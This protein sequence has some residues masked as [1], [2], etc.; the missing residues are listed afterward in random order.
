MAATS[1]ANWSLYPVA[2]ADIRSVR[3]DADL[4][5]ALQTTEACIPRG[6]GRCYGDAAL[7]STIIQMTRLNRFLDFDEATGTL[8]CE[9]GVS[10]ADI[11]KVF[12]PRG[13]FLP[14]TPGT[15]FVT[16]GGAMASDVHGKN[17]HAA[18]SFSQHVEAFDLM[19]PDGEVVTCTR[20][21]HADLFA[22]TLGGMGLTGIILRATF[23]LIPVESAFIRQET[24]K[25]RNLVEI[26]H[27]FEAS[28]DWTYSV[29]WIDC[30]ARGR[31]RGR[32]IMMRGEHATVADLVNTRWVDSP[33]TLPSKRKLTVPFALPSFTLNPWTVRAFN[34]AYYGKAPQGTHASIID[35]DTFFYPLDS[36]LHWNRIYGK[37]GFV[38][39]QFVLPKDM[40][41]SGLTQILDRIAAA[42]HGSFLAVLKLFGQQNDLIAFP[43]EG[44]TLALDFP[45]RPG[46]FDFLDALDRIVL[47]HGGRLYLTK[48]ARMAKATFWQ[49]YANADRFATLKQRIDP[50]SRLRSLQSD[51]L[52]LTSDEAPRNV[53]LSEAA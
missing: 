37:R 27:L 52:G 35:Y 22:A 20:A 19:L 18:G 26:M 6:L 53:S 38:Q 10:F 31:K 11:L 14:V 24:V 44:Y 49:S 32:S 33:L 39:H 50:A 12:V 25:A 2:Q 4:R 3:N 7:S 51:R 29:A 34:M 47:D 1:V 21:E 40:S 23:R 5:T 46:L 13:W 17:H 15:K 43:K 41:R 36:I 30:L 8:T 9:A 48:D 45:I 16:V 42:G 28:Q